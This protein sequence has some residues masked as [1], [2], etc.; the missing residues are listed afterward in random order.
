MRKLFGLCLFTVL[1]LALAGCGGSD[2]R[3]VF[4]AA[5]L[6]DQ[7]ADGDIAFDPVGQTFTITNGP[8]TLFFGIDDSDPNLPEFRAFLDF[9]L[10][11]STGQDVVPL[12][13]RI[14]SATLEVFID[15]VSFAPIIPTLLDLVSYPASGLREEDFDS[16]PLLTQELDFFASD[17]GR[18]VSIDVT[19]LMREAQRLGVADFQ[20]RFLLDLTVDVGL[21]GIEDQP[22]VSITAPLLTVVYAF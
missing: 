15:S 13:A 20:V 16:P 8:D 18:F 14:I 11:G 10:D 22:I 4:E 7:P 6:S 17:Q 9:P 3:R 12:A 19:P 1:A 5:I 2:E 21:V